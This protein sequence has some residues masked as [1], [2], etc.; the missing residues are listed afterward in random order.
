MIKKWLHGVARFSA[1]TTLGA[2]LSI[3]AAHAS[4]IFIQ[5]SGTTA[6]GGDPNLITAPGAF[7]IG[8][9]YSFSLQNP[10][11]VIVGVYDGMGTPSLTFGG[12]PVA[13]AT[14][15]TYGFAY[16]STT[17]VAGQNLWD[18]LNLSGGGSESF[19]NW[20]SADTANGFSA[21]SSF[22]L[23]VFALG[24]S[25]DSSSPVTV[26]VSGAANGSYLAAYGCKSGTGSASGCAKE[27]DVAQTVFTNSGLV[28]GSVPEP[29]TLALF[30]VGL[31]G[32]VLVIARR[33]R[34]H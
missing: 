28:D 29:G 8:T 7:T 22:S 23:Y 25:L 17:L 11:L 13:A 6:A 18:Q 12:S 27:G 26:G 33:R 19:T 31:L 5:Q 34:R 3:G 9:S 24:A 16:N 4:Q 2:V 20:S 32:C 14:V 10:L 30:A 1:A 21:P 15:G